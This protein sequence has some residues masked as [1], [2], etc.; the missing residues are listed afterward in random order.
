MNDI[1]LIAVV[2]ICASGKTTLVQQ[3]RQK[4]YSA[5][6]V[7]QEHSEV[8]YLWA[9]H[10]PDFLVHLDARDEIVA[11]RRSYLRPDRLRL[12]R[13][14]LSYARAK[15]NLVLD[16]SEK[17]AEMVCCDVIEALRGMCGADADP[18]G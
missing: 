5:V 6:E 13:E 14:L 7:A 10:N 3:L 12:E 11:T 18:G 1:R 17:S 2:G 4:G 9:R 15:A 8:P 16:T